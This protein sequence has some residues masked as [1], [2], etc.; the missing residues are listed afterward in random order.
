LFILKA[1]VFVYLLDGST[2]CDPVAEPLTK[3]LSLGF[4]FPDK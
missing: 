4:D 3:A 1:I 2:V